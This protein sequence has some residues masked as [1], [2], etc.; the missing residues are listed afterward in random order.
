MSASPQKDGGSKRR[1]DKERAYHGKQHTDGSFGD[2][3][4]VG[5]VDAGV[6][7]AD[8]RFCKESIDQFVFKQCK[9]EKE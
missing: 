1:V 7:A 4:L 9:I 2:T 6:F 8:V 3:V 5:R